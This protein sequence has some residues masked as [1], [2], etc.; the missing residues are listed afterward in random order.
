MSHDLGNVGFVLTT[1]SL[2]GNAQAFTGFREGPR[3]QP[4]KPFL[5]AFEQNN[6]QG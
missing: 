6:E 3:H 1:E 5:I 4:V 2:L